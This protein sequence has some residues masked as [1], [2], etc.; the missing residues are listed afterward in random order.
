MLA[1]LEKLIRDGEGLAVEFKR[2]E[3]KLA[4]GVYETVS[5]FSNRYGGYLILGVEDSGGGGKGY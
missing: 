5:A 4:N 2:C 3:N 1:K